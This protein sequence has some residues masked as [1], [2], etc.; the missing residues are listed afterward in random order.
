MLKLLLHLF[1]LC[2]FI[3]ASDIENV[4]QISYFVPIVGRI[5]QVGVGSTPIASRVR[6]FGIFFPYP[7]ISHLL[8]LTLMMAY[9]GLNCYHKVYLCICYLELQ[10]I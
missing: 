5:P 6:C 8:F 3:G 2:T 9:L 1:F 7:N 10:Y 4:H